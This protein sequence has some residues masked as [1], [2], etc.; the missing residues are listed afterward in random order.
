MIVGIAN[1]QLFKPKCRYQFCTNSIAPL[2]F[3][4]QYTNNSTFKFRN[5][6]VR[7]NSV[8]INI[9]T[10]KCLKMKIVFNDQLITG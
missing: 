9:N 4:G 1:G 8:I 2:I 7:S 3:D 5:I 10:L 6:F